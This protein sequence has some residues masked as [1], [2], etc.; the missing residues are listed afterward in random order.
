MIDS[1]KFFP[2]QFPKKF[3]GTHNNRP[4]PNFLKKPHRTFR[5]IPASTP[6]LMQP[7]HKNRNDNTALPFIPA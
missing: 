3:S 2:K 4:V 1:T 6:N 7:T 5:Q